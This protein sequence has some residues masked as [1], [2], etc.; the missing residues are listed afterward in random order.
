MAPDVSDFIQQNLPQAPDDI[1]PL[2]Q[3][4][5]EG[6]PQFQGLPPAQ[7]TQEGL[8]TLSMFQEPDFVPQ[9][10]Y[11]SGRA[12]DAP[13]PTAPSP[14]LTQ[15]EREEDVPLSPMEAFRERRGEG[16]GAPLFAFGSPMPGQLTSLVSPHMGLAAA[17]P[18]LAA[19]AGLGVA[20]TGPVAPFLG[21]LAAGAAIQTGV[22]EGGKELGL[23]P[24]LARALGFVAGG[25]P[26]AGVAGPTGKGGVTTGPGAFGGAG[27]GGGV[28]GPP[29]GILGGLGGGVGGATKTALRAADL[30]EAG[31]QRVLNAVRDFREEAAFSFRGTRAAQRGA[32]SKE[33]LG[34]PEGAPGA[35]RLPASEISR[36]PLE[37]T[38]VFL[39]RT[40]IRL[41]PAGVRHVGGS[42]TYRFNAPKDLGNYGPAAAIK[43]EIEESGKRMHPEDVRFEQV[44]AMVKKTFEDIGVP[45]IDVNVRKSSVPHL[46]EYNVTIHREKPI[47]VQ[48]GYGTAGPSKVQQIEAIEAVTNQDLSELKN[49]ARQL[50]VSIPQ[51]EKEAKVGLSQIPEEDAKAI[52]REVSGR[53]VV[54]PAELT[55]TEQVATIKRLDAPEAPAP[56]SAV[57]AGTESWAERAL[58]PEETASVFAKMKEDLKLKHLSKLTNSDLGLVREKVA[59]RA[60]RNHTRVGQTA[61]QL[62]AIPESGKPPLP[63]ADPPGIAEALFGSGGAPIPPGAEMMRFFQA[64]KAGALSGRTALFARRHLRNLVAMGEDG[65]E[66]ANRAVNMILDNDLAD[67]M[68]VSEI[69]RIDSILSTAAKK[70]GLS[71]KQQ[72]SFVE[73]WVDFRQGDYVPVPGTVEAKA[74]SEADKIATELS[75]GTFDFLTAAGVKVKDFDTVR[76]AIRIKGW[77][78]RI[79]KEGYFQKPENKA[80]V[81]QRAE[82]QF[83]SEGMAPEEAGKAAE[84]AVSD[85]ISLRGPERQYLHPRNSEIFTTGYRKDLGAFHTALRSEIQKANYNRWFGQEN[86]LVGKAIERISAKFPERAHEFE[87]YIKEILSTLSG[88]TETGYARAFFAEVSAASGLSK[89]MGFLPSLQNLSELAIRPAY[90]SAKS[91]LKGLSESLPKEIE[92]FGRK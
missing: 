15:V 54:S 67:T 75:D 33:F 73:R 61:K 39:S 28:G 47:P 17:A 86:A 38:E 57:K 88:K 42:V 2:V 82:E 68:L 29:R 35:A 66:I 3:Q 71:R 76:D 49:V 18:A 72:G 13:L 4:A 83:I 52:L 5:I 59:D 62:A 11:Y 58:S 34:V 23:P 90:T 70:L 44:A 55:A 20:S 43:R 84:K 31:A 19:T 22:E 89:I 79:H 14:E 1:D 16:P 21:R 63:P 9:S 64:E 91:F 80:L 50:D 60:I 26:F 40:G 46:G 69:G 65:A 92:D 6:I 36:P 30:G 56:T 77:F 53:E 41:D 51:A 48:L 24:W 87:P 10:S 45:S 32:I 81:L 25:T 27:A 8:E 37:I 7:P 74:Y 12:G 85:F 78:P